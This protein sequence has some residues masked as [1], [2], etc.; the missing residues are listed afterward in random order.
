MNHKP[1]ILCFAGSLRKDSFNKKVAQI[2]KEGAEKAGATVTYIDLLDYE[3]PLYNGDLEAASGIPENA[4]KLKALFMEHDGLLISLPEYNS[5][6]SAVF[7][8]CIDWVSRPAPGEKVFLCCFIDKVVALLSASLGELGGSRN[9]PQVRLMFQ[10]I[11]SIVLPK[12]KCIGKADQVFKSGSPSPE[13]R[14]EIEEIGA[15]LTNF[16]KRLS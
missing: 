10:N 8:N 7:K 5:G 6:M 4:M 15:Q 11:G 9:L 3:L 13:V 2:A 14:K 1:K 12:Q 16:L